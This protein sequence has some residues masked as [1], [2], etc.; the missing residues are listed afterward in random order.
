MMA[1][2]M[3]CQHCRHWNRSPTDPHNLGAPK[4]GECREHVHSAVVGTAGNQIQTLA[5]YPLTM[6][7]YPACGRYEVRPIEV[8][9][10]QRSQ[11]STVH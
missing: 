7:D 10:G 8:A 11:Q 1:T 5:Y 9:N 4:M 6:A 3:T 2:M